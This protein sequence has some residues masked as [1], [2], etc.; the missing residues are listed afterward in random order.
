MHIEPRLLVFTKGVRARID[1]A[2]TMRIGG[3]S[4]WALGFDNDAVWKGVTEVAR[5]RAKGATP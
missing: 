5:P 4:L 1:L 3:V 2:R